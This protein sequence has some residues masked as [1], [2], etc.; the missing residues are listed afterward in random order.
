MGYK[1]LNHRINNIS[2]ALCTDVETNPGPSIVDPSKTI[3]APY[4]QGNRLVFGSN[5]GKQC[6]AIDYEQSRFFSYSPSRA[7]RKKRAARKL[8][9]RKLV[10]RQA[11]KKGYR[12]SL[13]V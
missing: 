5:A 10:A 11:K 6:V 9:A 2:S 1:S 8:A 3:V 4:S 7:E 13:S 12:Q